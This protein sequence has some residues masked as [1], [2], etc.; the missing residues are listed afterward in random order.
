M[1]QQC[2][3]KCNYRNKL[4]DVIICRYFEIQVQCKNMYVHN[5]CIVPNDL[6]KCKYIAVKAT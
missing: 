1:G 6:F 4:P 5:K 3:Y 2:N